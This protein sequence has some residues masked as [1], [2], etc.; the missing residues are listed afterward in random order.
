MSTFGERKYGSSSGGNQRNRII[1]LI[2]VVF[3]TIV[4]LINLNRL[5]AYNKAGEI[6][7][8]Q[9]FWTG[10]LS[11]KSSAGVLPRLYGDIWRLRR[12]TS[13]KFTDDESEDNVTTHAV[14]V[15]YNDGGTGHW[16]GT[17]RFKFP[18]NDKIFKML[19]VFGS[20]GNT[21]KQLFIPLIRQIC[22]STTGLMSTE[23]SY[24]TKRSMI[25]EWC[26]D[27]ARKGVY[28][29]QVSFDTRCDEFGK[30]ITVPVYSPRKDEEGQ[31]DR[32]S[33]LLQQ[34][35]IECTLCKVPEI[36]YLGK[37]D[38]Q[39]DEKMTYRHHIPKSYLIFKNE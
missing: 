5:V 18:L 33:P 39:I 15:R 29:S 1:L 16:G 28:L 35:G 8:K 22:T 26:F 36:N 20:E 3:F 11:V 34:F 21:T 19:R 7:I 2:T 27:Q 25:P 9:A 12:E 30:T 17:A 23:E 14:F 31:I 13:V 4:F 24:T 38:D 6:I 10:T 37:I 32:K